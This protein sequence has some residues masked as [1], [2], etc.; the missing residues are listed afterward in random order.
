MKKIAILLLFFNILNLFSQTQHKIDYGK[1]TSQDLEITSYKND[2]TANALVIYDAGNSIFKVED[3]R[4]VIKTTYYQKIKI[5]NSEGFKHA[6]FNITIYRN[7]SNSEKVI[8]VKGITHNG[9]NKTYLSKNNVF[10]KTE[11]KNWKT[12]NFTMP[13]LKEGSIIEVMY[14][15]VTPFKYNLKGWEFQSDIPKLASQ[16]EALIPGNYLYNRSL[17]GYLKL[18]TN[19]STIKKHCFHVSGYAGDANCENILYRMENIPAFEEEK[20]MTS[21]DNFISKI[22]FELR[23]TLWFDGTRNKYTTTW[24]ETD[25]EFRSDKNIGL[26]FKKTR[27]F[28]ELIPVEIKSISN[29]L[30]RAKAVYSF[31]QNYFTWNGKYSIFKDVK[32]KK[33]IESKTGNVGELNISLINALKSVGLQAELVVLSTRN[34]GLPTKLYPVIS[35]FNYVIAKLNINNKVYLLDATSK[36]I[37]FDMIPFKCLNSYGRVMDFKNDS[38]WLPIK[39]KTISRTTSYISLILNEEGVIE[40]KLKK[41]SMGYQALNKRQD[42]I[43]KTEDEIADEFENTFLNITVKNYTLE[44]L[45][46]IDKPLIEIFDIVFNYDDPINN[47]YFNPFF[48][49]SFTESPFKQEKRMYPVDFG[50]KRNYRLN[51]SLELPD[52]YKI[53][54]FPQNKSIKLNKTNSTGYTIKSNNQGGYKFNLY[55]TLT[56]GKSRFNNGEYGY[57]KE[58]FDETI[59]SQKTPLVIS[60]ITN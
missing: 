3:D 2:T 43:G 47:I 22:K 12:V 36:Y 15:V 7:K 51:F 1:L 16:Y 53:K 18:T 46:D 42:Y 50:Y 17:S 29:E 49:G 58:I 10:T 33:A 9:T 60:K 23:E 4:V 20:Y 28:D 14:T 48:A 32:I 52:N 25:R 11:N 54:S 27:F 37:P 38:Y 39:A 40:G 55:S 59:T 24:E 35:D 56:I 30:D 21:K 8:D 41:V 19:S 31:I 57:L 26:Q 5:F 45:N 6:T 34:N 44:N 13:N